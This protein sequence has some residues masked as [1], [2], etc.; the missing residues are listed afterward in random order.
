MPVQFH[1]SYTLCHSVRVRIKNWRHRFSWL[2]ICMV[3]F[4]LF[5]CIINMM[6]ES[7]CKHCWNA[8][9]TEY[10]RI[11]TINK[12]IIRFFCKLTLFYLGCSFFF[13]CV[14]RCMNFSLA[15]HNRNDFVCMDLMPAACRVL[16]F[17]S[18][19]H[20]IFP[21]SER[22]YTPIFQACVNVRMRCFKHLC[23]K[24]LTHWIC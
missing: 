2:T 18:F 22:T 24:L 9:R 23:A 17:F 16:L 14:R 19:F 10:M 6:L 5:V 15:L 11:A 21:T 12:Q 4:C 1:S 8:S 13:Y 20:C 3:F 7:E